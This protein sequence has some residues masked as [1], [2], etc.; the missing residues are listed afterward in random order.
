MK[1]F[2]F[3][4]VV[5]YELM[6]QFEPVQLV[7]LSFCSKTAHSTV[8]AFTNIDQGIEIKSYVAGECGYSLCFPERP[9]FIRVVQGE[10]AF[11]DASKRITSHGLTYY[12]DG[13]SKKFYTFWKSDVV[14]CQKTVNFFCDLFKTTV[15][16]V[17]VDRREDLWM[18]EFAQR[19]QEKKLEKVVINAYSVSAEDCSSILSCNVTESLDCVMWV[20]SGYR[21]D[22]KLPSVKHL[23]I[24]S[25]LH[26]WI[27]QG[28]LLS[29]ESP[30]AQ[31]YHTY[32]TSVDINALLRSWLNGGLPNL[33]YLKI[34]AIEISDRVY[35]GLW[36][37]LES[38]QREISY[39][40]CRHGPPVKF[41]TE[42]FH[43]RREDHVVATVMHR[44][45]R[46]R[47]AAIGQFW[48]TIVVWP[49][50]TGNRV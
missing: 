9:T 12:F 44:S 8:K 27:T 7:C 22:G 36:D 15:S 19:R 28:N 48:F 23:C 50:I 42:A 32:L 10:K 45:D 1:I 6:K 14:G 13:Y 34:D 2:S 24:T 29:L 46:W 31:L 33:K 21:F 41:N 26:K 30:H 47:Y 35:E 17:T 3:P 39:E 5:V 11:L 18:L 16:T 43:I 25:G 40:R 20:P 4:H 49:D 37:R 38:V